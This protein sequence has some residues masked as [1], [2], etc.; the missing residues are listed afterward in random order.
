MKMPGWVRDVPWVTTFAAF[1]VYFTWSIRPT[2][3]WW[4]AFACAALFVAFFFAGR[5][6]E[7]GRRNEWTRKTFE[8]RMED[9]NDLL[10]LAV[11]YRILRERHFHMTGEDYTDQLANREAQKTH[12]A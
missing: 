3:D 4:A 7:L 11:R 2:W 9:A 5:S 8:Q 6:L 1:L 10:A 12:D